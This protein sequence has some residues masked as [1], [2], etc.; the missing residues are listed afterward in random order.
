M[1]PKCESL[2]STRLSGGLWMGMGWLLTQPN[3]PRLGIS[4]QCLD[5]VFSASFDDG[6]THTRITHL[7]QN[8]KHNTT[9]AKGEKKIEAPY[10]LRC[11]QTWLEKT[12]ME[13][14]DSPSSTSLIP[15]FSRDFP[16]PRLRT[17]TG[18]SP[19]WHAWYWDGECAASPCICEAHSTSM[20]WA[21]C[22]T[23]TGIVFPQDIDFPFFWLGLFTQF[24]S[25]TVALPCL[26]PIPHACTTVPPSQKLAYNP[27]N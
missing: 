3:A 16:L 4:G 5:L 21:L 22:H 20:Q 25:L 9:L 2:I 24:L 7:G 17:P 12:T 26:V 1:S 6:V 11:P 15:V 23:N 14:D 13:F 19:W 8:W 27:M 10:T 18:K